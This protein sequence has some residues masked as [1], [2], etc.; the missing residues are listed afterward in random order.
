MESEEPKNQLVPYRELRAQAAQLQAELEDVGGELSPEMEKLINEIELRS[1]EKIDG[2]SFVIDKIKHQMEFW[3][4][5]ATY[6]ED[7]YKSF[8]RVQK[9]IKDNLQFALTSNSMEEA[10]GNLRRVKLTKSGGRLVIDPRLVPKEFCDEVTSFIPNK[11]KIRA[12]LERF[13]D[14]PGAKIEGG[15]SIRFYNIKPEIK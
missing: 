15:L 8:E 13:E 11:E 5:Q 1:A 14:V 7:V 2:Y 4:E 3:E 6:A 12:A 9:R 10:R